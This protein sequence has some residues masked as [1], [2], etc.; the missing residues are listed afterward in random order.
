MTDPPDAARRYFRLTHAYLD[1]DAA[2][3]TSLRQRYLDGLAA[4]LTDADRVAELGCGTG[5]P[6]AAA[7][8][9]PA[10]FVGIDRIESRLRQAR[11]AVP[12]AAFLAADFTRLEF[13]PAALAAVVSF[14]ALIH[15]PRAGLQPLLSAVARWLRPGG[16]FVAALGSGCSALGRTPPATVSC[17]AAPQ[18]VAML[19]QA[20]LRV[21]RHDVSRL[22]TAAGWVEFTWI[23]AIRPADGTGPARWRAPSGEEFHERLL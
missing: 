8:S 18:L 3:P 2:Q 6:A 14:Y 15:V 11:Q 22:A 21:Q 4:G 23:S 17:V 19:G 5:R 12:G 20:G 16:E 1:W 9:G 13:G 10:R 7:L